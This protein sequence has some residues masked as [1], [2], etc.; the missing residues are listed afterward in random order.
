[1]SLSLSLGLGLTSRKGGGSAPWSPASLF[2]PGVG[3]AWYD[4]SDLST[5]FQ[6]AAGTVPVTGA[7]QPA[8]LMR[9][10]SGRGNHLLAPNDASRM[11]LRNAGG[12]WWLEGDGVDDFMSTDLL[13]LTN[14]LLISA[15][16]QIRSGGGSFPGPWRFLREDGSPTSTS[17]NRLEEYR[18][19]TLNSRHKIVTRRYPSTGTIYNSS[20]AR[21]ASETVS[22]VS[23]VTMRGASAR[24]GVIYPGSTVADTAA[25][26][27]TVAGSA[28]L[29][30][31]RGYRGDIM[32]GN[33]Y[34]GV[35]LMRAPTDEEIALTNGWMARK[36][37]V[38]P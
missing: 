8:R 29:D 34:G 30:L 33:F 36:T 13:G 5:M 2:S 20:D 23:W 19:N 11:I 6:D 35:F 32:K 37:G 25:T 16:M 26:K 28:T 27:A 10:K 17:D 12:L 1:M 15:G 14:E 9:D 24:Q 38:T 7:N 4:P 22:H 18:H 21:P 3:G 31:L